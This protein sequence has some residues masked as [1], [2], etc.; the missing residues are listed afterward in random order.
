MCV[1]FDDIFCAKAG[2]CG[3]CRQ[4]YPAPV[5]P[6]LLEKKKRVLPVAP[7][8]PGLCKSRTSI[9]SLF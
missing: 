7:G 9:S 1:Y 3:L 4:K 5:S 8:G 6:A 2:A